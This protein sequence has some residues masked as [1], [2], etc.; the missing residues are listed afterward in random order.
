MS[1]WGNGELASKP[2]TDTQVEFLAK[3]DLRKGDIRGAK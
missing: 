1:C 2:G 3:I